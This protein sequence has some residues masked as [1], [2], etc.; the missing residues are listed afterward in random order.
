[1]PAPK[2]LI[3]YQ[4]WKRKLSESNKG[5][6]NSPKTEFKRGNLK[7]KNAYKFQKGSKVNIGRI[8]WNKGEKGLQVAW[9]K[10]LKG[11]LAGKKHWQWKGGI[12]PE[13]T[14]I[15]NSTEIRL[16]R[17]SV[18]QKDNWICQKCKERKSGK[19]RSHHILNFAEYPKL[20]TSIENGITFCKNCHEEFHDKYGKKNNTKEQIEKFLK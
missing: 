8:P 17:K 14:K 1:M 10:G 13:N 2:D 3:E 5:K 4:E 7:S 6:H 11:Y 19:L 9:N 15:R 16:W 18:F 12:T 20:R